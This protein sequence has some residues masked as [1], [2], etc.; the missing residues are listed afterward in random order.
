MCT[1]RSSDSFLFQ[2]AFPAVASGILVGTV[3]WNLQQRDCSGLSPDSLLIVL[4][5]PARAGGKRR[6]HTPD[7]LCIPQSE[8]IDVL[9]D[10]G[11]YLLGIKLR[12]A[13]V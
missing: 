2:R 8:L 13:Q 12:I 9:T 1:G 11:S 6:T 5:F 7:N 10:K 4:V 3:A